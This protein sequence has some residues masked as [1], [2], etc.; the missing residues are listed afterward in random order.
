VEKA[1]REISKW[2]EIDSRIELWKKEIAVELLEGADW[3]LDAI[4]NISSKVDLLKH[5][6]DNKIKVF[7]SM[8]AGAKCDP[9]R[10]QI[11]DISSTIYDPMARSV[12]RPLRLQGVLSGIPV[13]Y[14]TEPPGDVKL[15]PLPEEE[16]QKGDV[17]ELGVLEDFR[18]RILP[19]LGPL[20]SIFGLHAAT[21]ILCELAKKPI[22]NPLPIK[23]RRK[24][25]ERIYREFLRREVKL[26]G[27]Q[28]NRLPIDEEEVGL[29]FEDV[30]H[31]RSIIPPHTVPAKPTLVRWDPLKPVTVDN[32]VPMDFADAEK[33]TKECFGEGARRPGDVW[34]TE[35]A[36]MYEKKAR[37]IL[38]DREWSM[39]L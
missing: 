3:V 15:L 12:R 16:F 1:L 17:K 34:G 27:I 13:V 33:H 25:Y 18:V 22:G 38:K 26:T 39:Q 29:I 2:V 11:S 9:T 31:G 5:C 21:Y 19:V 32:C 7:S 8:G 10:V 37:E 30:Y 35:V 20:P 36:S 23:N 28:L 6:H 4:D 14:S 24:L